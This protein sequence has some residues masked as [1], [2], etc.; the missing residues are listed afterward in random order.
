MFLSSAVHEIARELLEDDLSNLVF[1]S[2]A[3]Q[4]AASAI[5]ELGL[6]KSSPKVLLV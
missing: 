5:F 6:Q 2:S 4:A 1:P 3:E